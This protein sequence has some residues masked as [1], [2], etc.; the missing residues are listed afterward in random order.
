MRVYRSSLGKEACGTQRAVYLVRADL[1]VLFTGLPGLLAGVV[2]GLFRPLQQVDR[3]HDV[4][5]HED[6][7]VRDAAVDVRLRREIYDV[8]RIV[9]RNEPRDQFF[10]ADIAVDEHMPLIALDVLQILKVARIRERVKIDDPDVRILLKHVV[11][12]SRSDEAGTAGNEVSG[13]MG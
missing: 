6:L 1:H 11:N 13:H 5:G 3:T 12:E 4:R 2:P 7:R 10:V 8:I 9:L